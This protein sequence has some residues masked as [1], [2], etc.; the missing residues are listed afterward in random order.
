MSRLPAEP[1]ESI[2]AVARTSIITIE[3]R[4]SASEGTVA[5]A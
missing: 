2:P 5:R 1:A 4:S 3:P